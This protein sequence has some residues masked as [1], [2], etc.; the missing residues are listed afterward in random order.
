MRYAIAAMLT[1]AALVLAPASSGMWGQTFT[2]G[3]TIM[4]DGTMVVS[5]PAG[6]NE[7][8]E[9]GAVIHT[10]VTQ[11]NA[12]AVGTS[13]YVPRTHVENCVPRGNLTCTETWVV[14]PATILKG[15]F[16]IGRKAST[17]QVADVYLSDGSIERYTWGNAATVV[18]G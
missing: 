18:A 14:N 1:I 12:K 11:G 13:A 9:I 15:S 5:G 4:S 6:F 7:S 16:Q 10:T 17:V 8:D 3:V 2:S